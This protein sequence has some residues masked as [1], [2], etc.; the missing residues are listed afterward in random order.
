[1]EEIEAKL[2]E[3]ESSL[4]AHAV[5]I[6]GNKATADYAKVRADTA[7]Q[8][9]TENKSELIEYTDDRIQELRDEILGRLTTLGDDLIGTIGGITDGKIGSN[10]DFMNQDWNQ[11]TEE[12]RAEQREVLRVNAEFTQWI[13]NTFEVELPA[14]RAEVDRMVADANEQKQDMIDETELSRQEVL[15]MSSRWRRLA[16]DIAIAKNKIIEMDYSRYEER[17]SIYRNISVEFEDRFAEYSERITTAAG[18]IGAVADKVETLVASQG[19]QQASIENLERVMIEGNEQLAQQIIS[20]SV[21]TQTQFD[22]AKIWH[23]DTNVEGWTGTGSA[24]SGGNLK[25]LAQIASPVVS[26]DAGKYRQIRLR[27]TKVGVPAWVGTLDWEGA[28]PPG[29]MSFPEPEWKD[30]V[31]EITINPGWTGTLTKILLTLT[32]AGNASN[33]YLVDWIAIGRPS[34]GPSSAQLDELRQV[35]MDEKEV[36]STKLTALEARMEDPEIGETIATALDG[37]GSRVTLTEQGITSASEKI[38]V[39]ESKVN[40]P[41]TGLSAQSTAISGLNTKVSTAEGNITSMASDI[42][43]LTSSLA[44]KASTTA[45]TNLTTK[46]NE[47][48]G[49]LTALSSEV[50]LLKTDIANIGSST[51]FSGLETRVKK[52]EDDI[53]ATNASI[54]SLASNIN[55]ELG[56]KA[57]T[58]ALDSLTTRV[59]TAEGSISTQNTSI[60]ALQSDVTVTLPANIEAANAAAAA[61]ASTANSKG[62]VFFQTSAPATAERLSQNLWIDTTG[63]NNTPKRWNGSTWAVVTDKVAT[64][65]LAKA[66]EAFNGLSSKASSAA[67]DTLSNAVNHTTTGLAA[68]AQKITDL[69]AEIIEPTT[70]LIAKSSAITSLNSSVS[71]INGKISGQA[72]SITGLETSTGKY[73]AQGLFR[74]R[75]TAKPTGYVS[76]IALFAAGTDAETQTSRQAALFMLARPSGSEIQMVADRFAILNT[77]GDK[78]MVPFIVRNGLVRIKGAAIDDLTV[79]RLKIANGSVTGWQYS[80]TA[81][82]IKSSKSSAIVLA[83]ITIQ[84]GRANMMPIWFSAMY[85]AGGILIVQRKIGSGSWTE[86]KRV[87]DIG[88]STGDYGR[89][90]MNREKAGVD[91]TLIDKWTGTG[92]VSYRLLGETYALAHRGSNSSGGREDYYNRYRSEQLFT[93]RFLGAFVA[94]K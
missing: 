53:V 16:D 11:L 7:V 28:T 76:R 25:A 1:M 14:L 6:Q 66:N 62:K 3:F 73:S 40:D 57:T 92:R 33:H 32:S 69:R 54:T 55:T 35:V 87:T 24:W 85:P 77:V 89:G 30:G 8:T 39:L 47:E 50:T 78:K 12:M 20:M 91:H 84:K 72:E 52:T 80:Y 9:V 93:Q 90:S 59:S 64:D 51:A 67:F 63:G 70:G 31:G 41:N 26:I 18:D 94:H 17:E 60:T 56:K 22:P 74:V 38:T 71:T 43:T 13:E 86:I 48:A 36:T 61:A 68:T 27:V 75:T 46:V 21:G 34:P 58:S 65:A 83:Q 82:G 49:K 37:L 15:E 45:V 81:K 10:N 2:V 88:Y 29:P 44:G 79:G 4:M 19:D 23:Y 42:T 5:L